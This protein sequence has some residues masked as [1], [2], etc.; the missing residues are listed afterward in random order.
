[1]HGGYCITQSERTCVVYGMPRAVVEAGLTAE[2]LDLGDIA[3]RIAEIS[4]AG[5]AETSVQALRVRTS[6]R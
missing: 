1:M 6:E 5:E 2:I 3:Q 4:I